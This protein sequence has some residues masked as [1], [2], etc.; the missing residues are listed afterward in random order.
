MD[1]NTVTTVESRGVRW[2][3]FSNETNGGETIFFECAMLF[4]QLGRAK[5]YD[6]EC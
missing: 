1:G 2:I 5:T 3:R 6:A 4:N